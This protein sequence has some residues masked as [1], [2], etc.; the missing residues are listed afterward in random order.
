MGPS[1]LLRKYSE[2][3]VFDLKLN[4]GVVEVEHA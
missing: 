3:N 1:N 2:K 4:L